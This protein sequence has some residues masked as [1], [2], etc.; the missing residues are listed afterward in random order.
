MAIQPRT[1]ESNKH[2][3]PNNA[4]AYYALGLTYVGLNNSIAASQQLKKLEPLNKSLA[5]KL[6]KEIDGM[7]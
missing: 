1:V 4:N 5:D 6:S 7:K 3:A 2:S